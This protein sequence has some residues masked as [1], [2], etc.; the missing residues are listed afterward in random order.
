MQ[1]V[2]RGLRRVAGARGPVC[3]SLGYATEKGVAYFLEEHSLGMWLRKIRCHYC[4]MLLHGL[5]S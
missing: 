5:E 4:H 2:G 3:P 1:L